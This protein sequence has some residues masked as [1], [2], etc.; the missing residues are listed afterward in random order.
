MG[1]ATGGGG[2][3]LAAKSRQAYTEHSRSAL[4]QLR[5]FVSSAALGPPRLA[6]SIR[7]SRPTSGARCRPNASCLEVQGGSKAIPTFQRA[8][9]APDR[10][11]SALSAPSSSQE[12][13]ELRLTLPQK[14]RL[15]S[16]RFE[17]HVERESY[18]LPSFHRGHGE[19]PGVDVVGAAAH[20]QVTAPGPP[21]LPYPPPN[22]HIPP[23]RDRPTVTTPL[24]PRLPRAP[25]PCPHHLP[26]PAHSP[27]AQGSRRRSTSILRP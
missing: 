25:S 6:A 22:D 26:R 10:P 24:L 1:T 8:A 20:L 21:R 5:P 12:I 15:W 17:K 3:F 7:I 16:S 27:C 2:R 9:A 13:I 18:E 11:S 14:L 19:S 4:A 23:R